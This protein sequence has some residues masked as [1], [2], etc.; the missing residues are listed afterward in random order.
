MLAASVEAQQFDEV[1]LSRGTGEEGG[2]AI[3]IDAAGHRYVAG[4]FKGQAVFGAG[5]GAVTFNSRGVTDGFVARYDSGET[6]LWARSI[7]GVLSDETRGVAL[8]PDG[9]VYV[10]GFFHGTATFSNPA[11]QRTLTSRGAADIFIARYTADGS[12][13]WAVRAGGSQTDTGLAIAV[14]SQGQ[15]VVT[16]AFAGEARFDDS[17]APNAATLRSAGGNDIFLVA[18]G[19]DGRLR[20]ARRGGGSGNDG[21]SG[22]TVS[23]REIL[24]TGSFN[25]TATFES[26]A[27]GATLVSAGQGD[28]VVARY[29]PDG[30]LRWAR[31]AG[32][33]QFDSGLAIAV[34]QQLRSYV[35]GFFTGQATFGSATLRGRDKEVLVL[36]LD[37]NGVIQRASRGGGIGSDE[38]RG[39]AVAPDGRVY[40]TGRYQHLVSFGEGAN[41]YELP[42]RFLEFSGNSMFVAAYTADLVPTFVEGGGGETNQLQAGNAVATDSSGRAHVIGK[43]FNNA[44]AFGPHSSRVNTPVRGVSD[45]FVATYQPGPPAPPTTQIFYI[46]ST[47]GGTVDGIPFA[48]ED[49]L[50]FNPV[51]GSWTMLIDG[52]DIGLGP[53]D[54]SSFEW[55]TDGTMLMSFDTPI[56]LPGLPSVVEAS[57]IVRFFPERLGATTSGRFELFLKG[58]T[59][60]LSTDAERIDAIG[61][62]AGNGATLLST[63]DD[64]PAFAFLAEDLMQI[65]TQESGLAPYLPGTAMGLGDAAGENLSA[66]WHHPFAFMLI[67]AAGGPFTVRDGVSGDGADLIRC[68]QIESG[69]KLICVN[70]LIFDGSAHGFGGETIDA[71]SVGSSGV[72]GDIGEGGELDP[73][74]EDAKLFL[75]FLVR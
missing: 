17:A 56:T 53:T 44:A 23:G 21:A 60:G 15:A 35:T 67:Y 61:I 54:L 30:D 70:Q 40:V 7:G 18:Y 46:S 59:I 47:T 11:G 20:W 32:G 14:D 2:N 73:P 36:R 19:A 50:A 1:L 72:L 51:T 29:S 28:I 43:V 65:R 58:A 63:I 74:E 33:A 64:D 75:P 3:T 41:Q 16:G 24:L 62:R 9:S 12:L 57:D 48:D 4:H 52:S 42:P 5:P 34:D 55:L 8:G 6:L 37:S 71:F 66:V 49:V 25:G 69:R 10:T 31:G 45:M 39:I 38:G 22:L 26:P 13:L 27:D 68:D